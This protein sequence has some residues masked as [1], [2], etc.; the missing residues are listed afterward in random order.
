MKNL[1]RFASWIVIVAAAL[2]SAWAYSR[3]PDV[4]ATHWNAAG[5]ANGYTTKGVGLFFA[6]GLMLAIQGF[7]LLLLR[8]DPMQKNIKDMREKI[9]LLILA[10]MGFF[11]YVHGMTLAWNL[12]ARFDFGQWIVP[13]IGALFLVIGTLIQN[14]KPNWMFGIRTPW[15]L[16]DETVW[17]ETHRVGSRIFQAAG[18]ISLIGIIVPTAAIYLVVASALIAAFGSVAYSYV[19]YA[20][21]HRS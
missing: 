12:G 10:L 17:Q 4:V 8:M 9:D 7:I 14:A 5:V 11:A 16:S 19:A 15:T 2:A 6:P 18:V 3:V 13:A 21:R 20:R 1:Y